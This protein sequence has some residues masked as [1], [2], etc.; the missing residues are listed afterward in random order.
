MP[1]P[2]L[3]YTLLPMIFTQLQIADERTQDFFGTKA[4]VIGLF[5][6]TYWILTCLSDR[7]PSTSNQ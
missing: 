1:S 6:I 2:Y 7:S 4:L 5:P 3:R